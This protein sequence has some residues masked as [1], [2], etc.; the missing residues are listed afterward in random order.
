MEKITEDLHKFIVFKNV[1]K[2]SRITDIS[3]KIEQF[4]L[5]KGQKLFLENS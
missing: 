2:R 5:I 4:K 1:Q 3:K